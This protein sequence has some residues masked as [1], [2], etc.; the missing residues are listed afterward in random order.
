MAPGEAECLEWSW[1][2]E[3]SGRLRRQLAAVTRALATLSEFRLAHKE[4]EEGEAR[5]VGWIQHALFKYVHR[6]LGLCSLS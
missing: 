3:R 5:A 2:G 6:V 1:G 4:P